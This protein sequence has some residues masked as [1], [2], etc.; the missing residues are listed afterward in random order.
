M[1]KEKPAGSA[2]W[3]PILVA[4]IVQVGTSGDNTVLAIATN[5]FIHGLGATIDQVQLANIVY[6][7]FCG[8]LCVFFGMLGM[9]K[10]FKNLLMVGAV[11]CAAGEVVVV[12]ATDMDVV[13]WVAR[14]LMGLG[15]AMML[16]SILGIIVALYD[17]R[18]RAVA[19]GCVGAATGIA[20]ILMPIGAGLIIDAWGYQA[21]FFIMAVWFIAVFFSVWKVI[22]ASKPANVRVDYVGTVLAS[23]GLVMFFIG[24]FKI[25][26]WGLIAPLA[27]PFTILGISPALPL[28]LLGLTVLFFTTVIEKRIEGKHGAA[29]IPQSYLKTRQVRNG[30]YLTGLIFLLFGSTCFIVLSW[31]MLV[32]G[33]GGTATGV[34]FSVMAVPM[35]ILAIAIPKKFSHWSPRMVVMMSIVAAVSG[36]AC[37]LMSLRLDGFDPTM[38]YIGLALVG[39]GQGGFSSQSAMVVA[40]ALN[41]RDAAQSGGIQCSVRN[42]WHAG[43]FAIIG[44]VLLFSV[45]AKY[46]EAVEESH[47]APVV[48]EYVANTV[49]HGFMDNQ[50]LMSTLTDAGATEEEA[51]AALAIYKQARIE[52]G[53]LAFGALILLLLL[54]APGFMGIQTEGWTKKNTLARGVDDDD[55]MVSL[56]CPNAES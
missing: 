9:V 24:C 39:T 47:L 54:H 11:L 53:R 14:P 49:V 12:V 30:L 43:G 20:T 16:P 51:L 23:I 46:K 10:G 36:V 56:K 40:A 38:M 48:K 32:A 27:A 21:A 28:A 45:T 7:L 8:A 50:Q 18:E 3:L 44:A 25:S 15:A 4:C 37:I 6:A 33:K 34:A 55:A 42:V 41:P 35:I 52:S 2:A 13:V 29:L 22:P 19:F 17:K 1:K 26:T 5:Q 31:I